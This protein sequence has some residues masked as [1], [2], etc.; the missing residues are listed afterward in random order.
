M[1]LTNNLET[2]SGPKICF[3]Q[4]QQYANIFCTQS[5]I[6]QSIPNW[7]LFWVANQ[8][9]K[10][11]THVT[12][13]FLNQ[14]KFSQLGF[15]ALHLRIFV[16]WKANEK[17]V[18]LPFLLTMLCYWRIYFSCWREVAGATQKRHVKQSNFV[19]NV[20]QVIGEH[21]HKGEKKN[22]INKYYAYYVCVF[23]QLGYCS[24]S[25]YLHF[26]Y[27]HGFSYIWNNSPHSISPGYASV[28]WCRPCAYE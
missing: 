10:T 2:N 25:P 15:I 7:S 6:I 16:C 5:N 3:T 24:T 1:V 17:I 23:V 22:D 14:L 19:N 9:L 27:V 21:A 28:M 18:I 20:E 26:Q 12:V 13:S 8:A 11:G 4:A